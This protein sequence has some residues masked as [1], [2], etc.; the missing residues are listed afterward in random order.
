MRQ[1]PA[2]R[3]ALRRRNNALRKKRARRLVGAYYTNPEHF[4]DHLQ[5]CSCAGCGNPRR[6]FGEVTMA[7]MRASASEK[8]QI[9]DLSRECDE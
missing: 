8:A 4:A 3:H 7:E 5:H 9:G 1:D 2:Y 6:H